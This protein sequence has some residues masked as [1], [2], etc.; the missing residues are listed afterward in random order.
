MENISRKER[1]GHKYIPGTANKVEEQHVSEHER[2]QILQRYALNKNVEEFVEL[3]N[4]FPVDKQADLINMME[5]TKEDK[6]IA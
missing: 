6:Q 4:T 3:L 1:A 5:Y 2:L